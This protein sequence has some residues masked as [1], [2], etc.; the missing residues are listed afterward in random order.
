[1]K[2]IRMCVA[3]R[4]R[5]LQ[6]T[7]VRLQCN[8]KV[9]SLFQGIGRSFYICNSCIEDEKRLYKT[10]CKQCKNNKNYPMDLKEILIDVR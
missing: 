6:D 8:D 1:M 7:L 2:P 9:L 10:L 3:C 4:E 5:F